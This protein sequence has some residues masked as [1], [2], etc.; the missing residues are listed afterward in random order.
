MMNVNSPH[1]QKDSMVGSKSHFENRH[2]TQSQ[3]AQ[4]QNY[5]GSGP[6]SQSTLLQQSG[7]HLKNINILNA[8]HQYMK[9]STD[10]P[11]AA[12]AKRNHKYMPLSNQAKGGSNSHDPNAGMMLSQNNQNY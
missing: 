6:N 9:T 2:K 5:S 8:Q 7:Q 1:K 3:I 11:N 12:L 10:N 4:H